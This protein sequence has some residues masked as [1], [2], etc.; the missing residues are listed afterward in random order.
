MALT[1]RLAEGMRV[2]SRRGSAAIVV[3]LTTIL[4]VAHG[5]RPRAA[6]LPD[7]LDGALRSLRA[8]STVGWT[9]GEHVVWG[10][11]TFGSDDLAWGNL[12]TSDAK[13]A[14]TLGISSKP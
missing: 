4:S 5:E 12:Y 7:K 6:S 10:D 3:M 9:E 13:P 11:T 14:D 1:L 2:T 8:D